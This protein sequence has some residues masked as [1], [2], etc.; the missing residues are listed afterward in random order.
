MNEFRP[1]HHAPK[2]QDYFQTRRQFLSRYGT[3][4]GLLG[5][6]SMLEPDL[7]NPNAEA[8]KSFSPLAV[9]KPHFQTRAKRAIHIFAQGAPSHLDTWDYK[10]SLTR[11]DAAR[12]GDMNGKPLPDIGGVAFASPVDYMK[13]GQSG[14]PVAEIWPELGQHIDDIAVINSM[15][16]DIPAHEFA[17]VMMNTGSGRLV[18]PSMGSWVTYGL[19]SENQNLPGFISLTPGGGPPGGSEN[20][21]SAFLPGSFQGTH[22]N[23]REPRVERLIENIK[24][25]YISMPEQRQQLDLLHQLNAVHSL[26]LKKEEQLEAR[27]QAFELAFKMQTEATE[28]FDI[29]KE[30]QSVRDMYGD[31]AQGRQMLIAR[32]LL[33]KGVR[34]VQA[35]H[36]GWDHHSNLDTAI[37][38]KAR[39]V[40]QPIAAFIKDLKN[41]GMFE[42]TLIIWSGE[43][44]RTPTRQLPNGNNNFEVPGRNHNHR[45]FSAWMAGGGVKGGQRYGA[46]DEFGYRAVSDKVHIHDLHATVLALLGFDHEKLTYRYNG[47]DFRLTDVYGNVVRDV[48]A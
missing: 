37:R 16:T 19:G 22:I 34:F 40:D 36:G 21:R 2:A 8:A 46:T 35:W 27:I 30:P 3:G 33:E 24:N 47:R 42:E 20:W 43:F 13:R 45:G 29:S 44:G 9:K 12:G 1:D 48:I 28:V 41:R 6:A 38:N 11:Y 4:F 18:K 31:T 10:P 26:N 25:N 17:S 5:L 32:R 14:V 23:T 15:H 7:I 39:E